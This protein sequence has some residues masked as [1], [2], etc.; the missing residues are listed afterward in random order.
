MI[1]SRMQ[2]DPPKSSAM[3]DG[4]ESRFRERVFPCSLVFPSANRS[5]AG[6]T[7]SRRKGDATVT[8]DV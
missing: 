4:R 1:A 5:L 6:G 2:T 8:L 3:T 7:V